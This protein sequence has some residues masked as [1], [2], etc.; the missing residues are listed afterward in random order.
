MQ[1]FIK[2]VYRL[3]RTSNK[4]TLPYISK[5]K[6]AK[7]NTWVMQV[8]QNLHNI[9]KNV[10]KILFRNSLADHS[11][12]QTNSFLFPRKK[13]SGKIVRTSWINETISRANLDKI[14]KGNKQRAKFKVND[15][16]HI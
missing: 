1:K 6:M 10:K 4:T 3:W 7:L 11:I 14:K 9:L 2:Q 8:L 12:S 16:K 5:I 15:E 13:Y